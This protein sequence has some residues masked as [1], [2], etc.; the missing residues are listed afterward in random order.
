[1]NVWRAVTQAADKKSVSFWY[2]Y[3][4]FDE[5]EECVKGAVVSNG[6]SVGSQFPS[7]IDI[8]R[9]HYKLKGWSTVKGSNTVN[10]TKDTKVY[11]NM[12]VYAEIGRAHV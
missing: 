3:P 1:M 11:S 6:D 2:D 7:D 12:N 8:K 10:F 5:R 4:G 9:P